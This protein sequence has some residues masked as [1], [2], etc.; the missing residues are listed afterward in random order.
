VSYHWPTC[1][2]NFTRERPA[3]VLSA[4]IVLLVLYTFVL[5]ML[6]A[7]VLLAAAASARAGVPACVRDPAQAS[8]TTYKYPDASAIQDITKNCF[9]MPWM[10][11]CGIRGGCQ[12]GTVP[13]SSP[14]CTPFSVLASSCADHEM[15]GMA[16]CQN[17]MSLCSSHSVVKQCNDV[18]PVPSLVH[19]TESQV[20]VAPL[21]QA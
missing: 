14:Y 4:Y 1:W 5:G 18:G 19:T 13:K 12:N 9:E 10:I 7:T 6:A 2:Y 16:G 11:G 8:C 3:P 21:T 15:D 20:R 17:Y